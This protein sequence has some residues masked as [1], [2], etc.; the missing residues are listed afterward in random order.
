MK[1]K[2]LGLVL[3][4]LLACTS[5]SFAENNNEEYEDTKNNIDL[6][7]DEQLSKIN[8]DEIEKYIKEDNIIK[9]INLKAYIEDLISGDA[10]ILDLFDKDKIKTTKWLK[11]DLKFC[12]S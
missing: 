11:Q 12:F 1:N 5:L 8:I 3:I 9:D 2:I 4:I 6:Y 10:N 7:I